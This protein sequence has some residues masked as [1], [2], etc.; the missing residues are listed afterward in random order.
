MNMSKSE[1]VLLPIL[2]YDG[3]CA[4]C[5]SSVRALQ[6]LLKTK[7]S[8][9]PYQFLDLKPYG[10]TPEQCQLE[11]KFARNDASIAGGHM[12]FIEVFKYA[13]KGWRFLAFLVALPG[14]RNIAGFCYRWVAKN[15]YR[16]PGGTPTC[17]LPK[18]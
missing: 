2:I 15:R 11:A 13:G 18:K 1:S 7:P 12:A 6:K 17:A 14:F 9:E 4:F 5:S 3:D 8:M 16:L 10:L